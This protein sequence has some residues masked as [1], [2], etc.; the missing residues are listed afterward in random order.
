MHMK[1]EGARWVLLGWLIA[2]AA[3][4]HARSTPELTE[5]AWAASFSKV[6]DFHRERKALRLLALIGSDRER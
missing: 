5:L 2:G 3:L 1:D 6:D 4:F